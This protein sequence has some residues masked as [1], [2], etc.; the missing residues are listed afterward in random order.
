[1]KAFIETYAC[2]SRVHCMTCRT[3]TGFRKSTGAPEVC[4]HGITETTDM[5]IMKLTGGKVITPQP[6]KEKQGGNTI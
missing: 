2:K 3:S 6:C 1:M 5:D 4:P